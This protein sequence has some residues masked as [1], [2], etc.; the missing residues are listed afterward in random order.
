MLEEEKKD[1]YLEARG[2]GLRVHQKH[3]KTINSVVRP[4]EQKYCLL[5]DNPVLL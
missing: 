3:I 2:M 1:Q 5:R 4:Q